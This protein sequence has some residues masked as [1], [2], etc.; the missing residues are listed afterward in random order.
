MKDRSVIVIT[1]EEMDSLSNQIYELNIYPKKDHSYVLAEFI[2]KN[3]IEYP[4]V[5]YAFSHDIVKMA[6]LSNIVIF[7]SKSFKLISLP[8]KLT[9]FQLSQLKQNNIATINSKEMFCLINIT[10]ENDMIMHDEYNSSVAPKIYSSLIEEKNKKWK[11]EQV[12][13]IKKKERLN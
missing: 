13:K 9:D 6:I 12:Y 2:K 8:D 5:E 4:Y 7:K 10:Q 3:K 1:G 11:A